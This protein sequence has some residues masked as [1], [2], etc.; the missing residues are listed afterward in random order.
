[1]VEERKKEN[2]KDKTNPEDPDP[3][4]TLGMALTSFD[5]KDWKTASVELK[6]LR[7]AGKLGSRARTEI[8][9]KTGETRIVP[10]DQYWE[11][12]YKYYEGTRQWAK[13]DPSND[14]AQKEL[15]A[16]KI[17]L[18]R[19]YVAGPDEVG[20]TKWRDA[21]E[22]LRKELIPDLDVDAL[23]QQQEQEQQSAP[24]APETQPAE[25]VATR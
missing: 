13:A 20:G 14:D 11:A 3:A 12:M 9:A 18:R 6:R 7:F 24:E 15:E 16:V 23:R 4:V 1:M 17:L 2:P 22:A 5:L 19:D 8:D 25:P 21:F 10:N